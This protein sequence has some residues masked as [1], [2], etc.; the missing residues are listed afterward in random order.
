MIFYKDLM[1]YV[2]KEEYLKI[3]EANINESNYIYEQAY[4]KYLYY[5]QSEI[6]DKYNGTWFCVTEAGKYYSLTRDILEL[7]YKLNEKINFLERC[8][9]NNINF[10]SE[11]EE[12]MKNVLLYLDKYNDIQIK[13]VEE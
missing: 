9:I 6:H 4:K 1:Y 11:C 3:L 13:V 5:C 2:T 8:E 12:E 7:I 10:N